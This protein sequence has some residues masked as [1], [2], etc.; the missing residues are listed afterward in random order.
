MSEKASDEESGEG[1]Q[2]EDDGGASTRLVLLHAMVG[3]AGLAALSWEVLWQLEASLALGISA[4]GTALTLATTMG[5]LAL[6]SWLMGRRIRRCRTRDEGTITRPLRIYAAL[7]AVVGLT[8][9]VLLPGL[10]LV[11]RLDAQAFTAGG[12]VAS[13][14]HLGGL[15]CVLGPPAVAM[16]ATIPMI[17]LA[18]RASGLPPSRLYALNTGG[19]C[20]GVFVASFV[21]LPRLGVEVTTIALTCTNL[22]VAATALLSSRAVATSATSEASSETRNANAE[23]DDDKPA[24]AAPSR[25]TWIAVLASG[26]LV[27]VLEVLWF[28]AL[29]AAFQATTDAFAVMLAAV[30]LALALGARLSSSLAKRKVPVGA[31]LVAAG[32]AVLLATPLVERFDGFAVSTATLGATVRVAAWFGATLVVLSPALLLLGVPLPCALDRVA[33][34]FWGRIYAVNT[35]AAVAGS[36]LGAWVVLPLLGFARGAWLAGALATVAGAVLLEARRARALAGVAGMVA[37]VVAVATESG[38]GRRRVMSN[39]GP[40]TR[41]VAFEEG[42]DATIAVGE[43][44]H[45]GRVLLVDGFAAAESGNEG[46]HYMVW[47]GRLPMLLHPAPRRALV[48]CFGTGQTANAVRREKPESLDIVDVNAAVFRMAPHFDA[49]E[50]V[51]E[52]KRVRAIVMDGRAWMRRTPS[53]YEIIT[54]EPMPPNFSG[55]NALYSLEFYEAAAAR[56]EA[57]G[58]LAQWMPFHILSVHDAIAI[59]ATFQRV[60]PDSLIWMDPLGATGIIVGR[61]GTSEGLGSAW[62]GFARPITRDLAPDAIKRSVVVTSQGVAGYAAMGKIITDDNQMLAFGTER[63]RFFE[64]DNENDAMN[65]LVLDEIARRFPPVR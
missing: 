26:S 11:A 12:V 22:F 44:R 52:D 56:L 38:I 49:N 19:A 36:L 60:F 3:V 40:L 41:I 16:G 13:L 37:L 8:G 51:L 61:K 18:A 42:A 6:G 28:R 30:L 14:V 24:E 5:G 9:L 20:G 47:M 43:G 34:K 25:A 50:R 53:R 7:E 54:L 32:V 23:E 63:Y 46:A 35:L 27:F 48:I 59:A 39:L 2:E 29:R 55:V 45:G 10:R 58:I 31:A 33:P 15:A 21:L 65:L 1:P 62:P 64:K 4:R 57:G 17:A